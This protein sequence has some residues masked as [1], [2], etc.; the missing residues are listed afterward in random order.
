MVGGHA[1]TIPVLNAAVDD[2][3]LTK[4]PCHAQ[5]VRAPAA[6]TGRIAPWGA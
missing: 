3:H 1:L 4:N 2:G 6:G 5:S